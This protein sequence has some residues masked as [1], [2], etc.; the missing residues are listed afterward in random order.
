[1]GKLLEI[2]PLLDAESW[3]FYNSVSGRNRPNKSP[4]FKV[5]LDFALVKDAVILYVVTQPVKYL[6]ATKATDTQEL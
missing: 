5:H 2:S 6:I 3:T 1:M 4:I